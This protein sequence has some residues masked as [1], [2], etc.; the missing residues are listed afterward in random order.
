MSLCVH[1]YPTDPYCHVV[2]V[3]LDIIVC[4]EIFPFSS[5]SVSFF[6]FC[7]GHAIKGT[8]HPQNR[9]LSLITHPHV[10]PNSSEMKSESFQSLH[11]ALQMQSAVFSQ[12]KRPLKFLYQPV[13]HVMGRLCGNGSPKR[14]II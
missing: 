1:H 6:F 11:T 5:K 14:D 13:Q 4:Q 7:Q 12:T 2:T 8:V 10:A 3:G 9:I